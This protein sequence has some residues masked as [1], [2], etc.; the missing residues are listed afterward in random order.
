MD[1]LKS[2]IALLLF[3]SLIFSVVACTPDEESKAEESKAE[4][5]MAEESI[6]TDTSNNS[7]QEESKEYTEVITNGNRE[8]VREYRDG[9]NDYTVTVTEKDDKGDPKLITIRD[10]KLEVMVR[11][12]KKEYIV[13][14]S[15]IYIVTSETTFDGGKAINTTD[16]YEI[17]GSIDST[18]LTE[19]EYSADEVSNKRT[20]YKIFDKNGNETMRTVETDEYDGKAVKRSTNMQYEVT[21]G[22]LTLVFKKVDENN[23]SKVYDKNELLVLTYEVTSDT[24]GKATY[25]RNGEIVMTEEVDGSDRPNVVHT[26]YDSKNKTL[27]FKNESGN[28]T[29][30]EGYINGQPVT[31]NDDA[32]KVYNDYVAVREEFKVYSNTLSY[33]FYTNG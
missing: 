3:L 8:T 24:S 19:Y 7:E 18:I 12:V 11:E 23:G 28:I 25:Y 26:V 14:N 10:Y 32:L 1:K 31:T 17:D 33:E 2:I 20:T 16:T 30:T 21:D 9:K 29:L 13:Q 6:D 22:K 4:E 5:S 27:V 15:S